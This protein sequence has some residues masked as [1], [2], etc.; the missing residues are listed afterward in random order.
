[1]FSDPGW[2]WKLPIGGLLVSFLITEVCCDGYQI[3]TIK[4]LRARKRHPL[5]SWSNLGAFFLEGLPLRL[6]IYLMYLPTILVQGLAVLCWLVAVFRLFIDD[7]HD[8]PF[9]RYLTGVGARVILTILGLLA[10]LAQMAL[11]FAVPALAR[12]RADGAS[13]L[14]LLAPMPALRLMFGNFTKYL[15]G[16]LSVFVLL[17]V[18]SAVTGA[19]GGLGSAIVIGPLLAWFLMAIGRFWGRLIWAYHLAHAEVKTSKGV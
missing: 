3:E 9:L 14:A 8:S 11:F 5:P 18:F 7:E 12:R 4:N 2:Y 15:W 19:L 6:A 16:R 13:F 17:L 1:V 10:T